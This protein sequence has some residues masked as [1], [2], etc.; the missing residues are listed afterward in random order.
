MI[1]RVSDILLSL[2]QCVSFVSRVF[3]WFAFAAS[4]LSYVTLNFFVPDRKRIRRMKEICLKSYKVLN[5]L[6]ATEEVL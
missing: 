3:M 4:A 2:V 6:I 1:I 5:M